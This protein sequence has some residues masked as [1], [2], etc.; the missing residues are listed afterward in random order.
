[1]SSAFDAIDSQTLLDILREIIEEDELRIIRF[2]LSDTIINTRINSATKEKPFESKIGSPPG[3]SL[4]P[5]LFSIYLENALKE[6][7]TIL[8]RPTSDF[9]KTLPTEIV[10][11][12]DVDFIRLEFADIAEV[13][14]TLKKYNLLVN[15]DKTEQTK[16]SRSS[17]DLRQ[18]VTTPLSV[19]LVLTAEKRCS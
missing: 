17:N 1:M 13:Q 7:R 3:D 18:P 12:D 8:P 15:A 4:S 2:L 5:V 16:L 9:E 19:P 6:V 10:Y 11:A 14:K